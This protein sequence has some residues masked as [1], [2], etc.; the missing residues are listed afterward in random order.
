MILVIE[1]LHHIALHVKDVAESTNFYQTVLGLVPLERPAF[2]FPGAWFRLGSQQELHL[3]GGREQQ[4][5]SS[6]HSNHFALRVLDIKSTAQF[7]TGRSM[8]LL[9]PK[10]R[11]DGAWQIFIKDPDGHT[12]EFCQL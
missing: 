12:I 10:R 11:A 9:G 4:V 5:L 6:N 2:A 7:L 8:E 3:I 1:E